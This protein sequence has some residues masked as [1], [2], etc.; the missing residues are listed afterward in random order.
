MTDSAVH[1]FPKSRIATIDIGSLGKSKHHVTALLEVDV[2]E[3]RKNIRKY[4]KE[5]N[6]ASFTAWLLKAIGNAISETPEVAGFLKGKR[7]SVVFADVNI[8]VLVEKQIGGQKVPFPLVIKEVNK[9]SLESIT[10]QLEEA[11]NAQIDGKDIVLQK[12]PGRLERMYY[13]LPGYL[14]RWT[15]KMFLRRPEWVFHKMGNVAV[16]SIGMMGK[17]NG[18]FIPFS[19]HPLCFGISSVVKKPVVVNDKIEIREMMNITVL[20]DHDV[21]DGAPMARFINKMVRNIENGIL[22]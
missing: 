3:S 20:L 13:H 14:R 19:V 6:R 16:T 15:W 22:L 8:S 21:I 1:N 11:K 7:K 5:K 10:N 17:I 18:W 9:S 12:K 4:R 2:T